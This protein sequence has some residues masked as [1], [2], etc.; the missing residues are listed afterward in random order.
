MPL[1]GPEAE[2]VL[3]LEVTPMLGH[4]APDDRHR[5]GQEGL[6]IGEFET[7]TPQPSHQL[8]LHRL[9]NIN[10]IE[11]AAEDRAKQVTGGQ[12][13]LGFVLPEQ[14]RQSVLI[15]FTHPAEEVRNRF[16]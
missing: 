16:G 6:G 7:S 11:V 10:G 3:L 2:P 15:P 13:D 5:Q 12:P 1:V 4:L 14:L 9:G 8:A